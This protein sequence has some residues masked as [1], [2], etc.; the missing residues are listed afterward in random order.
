MTIP[1][2]EFISKY[3]FNK[4][5]YDDFLKTKNTRDNLDDYGN[6][7]LSANIEESNI[8]DVGKFLLKVK[9]SK[10]LLND[11]QVELFMN[12]ELSEYKDQTSQ[13]IDKNE[14]LI[15]DFTNEI[16][17]EIQSQLD[18]ENI[19]QTQITELSEILDTEI[20]KNVKFQEK[21]SENFNAAKDL[22]IAQRISLGEGKTPSDFSSEFPFLPLS[23]NEE[24]VNNDG[25]P[26]ISN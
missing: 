11:N 4:S 5:A 19:L 8:T 20:A 9:A 16:D 17:E 3:D 18:Q 24:D 1:I 6:I 12:T 10:K 22:I 25:F 15:S 21:S 13:E 2:P 23:E 14:D 7:I 26:F